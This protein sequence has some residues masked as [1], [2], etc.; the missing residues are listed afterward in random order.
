MR[1]LLILSLIILVACTKD[2]YKLYKQANE[3]LIHSADLSSFPQIENTNAVFYYLD[4]EEEDLLTIL[5]NSGMNT[6]RLKLWYSPINNHSSFEEVKS[7]SQRLKLMDLKIWITVHYSDTWA[8]PGHQSPPLAWQNLSFAAI[9]DSVYSYTAK[10]VNEIDPEFIQIGNEINTGLIFPHGRISENEVQFLELLST[11]IKAVR[12]ISN[13]T[14]IIIH[15][16]GISGSDSFYDRINN[17]DYDIIGLSYYPIWHSKNL[18]KLKLTLSD[19]SKT[20]NKDILIAETAYPFT[21]EWNDWTNNV[22]GLDE[23]LILPDYPATPQGQKDFM[24]VINEIVFSTE[25]GIGFCYWGGELI[26]FNGQQ[27]VDG[28]PWENQA[29]FDFNNQVLPVISMF[30]GK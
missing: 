6:V 4:G 22:V 17:L 12:D 29:L 15:Y 25:K 20:Y 11:G 14:E 9:K 8:D 13:K 21:M 18:N 1:Y 23:H 27:A 19:L 7:F 10:I 26:A 30:R 2:I 24:A 16:A 5:K 3:Q 28:S